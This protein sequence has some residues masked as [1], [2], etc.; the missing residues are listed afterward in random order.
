MA[1]LETSE[2]AGDLL[3]LSAPPP[4]DDYRYATAIVDLEGRYLL[5][6]QSFAGLHGVT[7]DEL[8]GRCE[9]ELIARSVATALA[10]NDRL[11]LNLP[12][13]VLTEE[14]VVDSVGRRRVV[15]CRCALNGP[16]GTPQAVCRMYGSAS[17]RDRIAAEFRQLLDAVDP[18]GARRRD[19][20]AD[21]LGG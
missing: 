20:E 7:P 15:M 18:T 19:F 9:S 14:R 6:N 4:I 17:A 12:A 1:G 3:V 11:A 5:V 2:L 16:D 21:R 8:R 10:E 13:A